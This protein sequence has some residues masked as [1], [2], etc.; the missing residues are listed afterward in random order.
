MCRLLVGGKKK[1]RKKETFTAFVQQFTVLLK[2]KKPMQKCKQFN[3]SYSYPPTHKQGTVPLNYDVPSPNITT[4]SVGKTGNISIFYVHECFVCIYF[5]AL[6]VPS[7]HGGQKKISI[8]LET[9]VTDGCELLCMC[10]VL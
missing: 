7:A 3:V 8:S 2:K 5:Y 9:G 4:F 6:L 10:W 1:E